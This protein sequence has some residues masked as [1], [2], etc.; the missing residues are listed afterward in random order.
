V[1]PCVLAG[2]AKG[3]TV[4]DPFAGAGTTGLV[5]LAK[6]RDFVGIELNP[7]YARMAG[8]RIREN[9]PLAN[10]VAIHSDTM[11]AAA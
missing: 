4:L 6:E 8:E 2:S 5:A 11:H 9:A 3:D 1:E 10:E 7:E